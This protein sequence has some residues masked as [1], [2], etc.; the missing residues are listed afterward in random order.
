MRLA[1]ALAPLIACAPPGPTTT[2]R[3]LTLPAAFADGAPGATT[4]AVPWRTFFADDD[5]NRLIDEALANNHDLQIALARIEVARA[6]VTRTSGARLPEIGVAATASLRRFGDYTMD[7]AGNAATEIRPGERVPV[8]YPELFVGLQASWEADLWGRLGKLH[9]AARA[10]YL[11]SIE[12]THLVVANLVADLASTYYELLAID[13]MVAITAESVEQQEHALEL[14]RVEKQTGR[15]TALAV[16]QFSAQ[17]ATTRALAAE[18]AHQ[19]RALENQ[20]TTLAG[21][22]PGPL[23]RS[24]ESLARDVPRA[25]AAGVPSDLLR[26]RPDLR[27]AELAVTASRYDVGAARAAFYPR[28]R[29][30]ATLGYQAFDP[31]FLLSTPA[32]LAYGVAG[33]LVAPLVNRAAIKADLAIANATQLE[34]MVRYQQT[35]LRSFAEVSTALYRLAQ[36]GDVVDQ[37][38]Q[39]LAALTESETTADALFRAGRATYL[40]VLLAQQTTLQSRLELV[41]ALRDRQLA[42]VHLYKALGGGWQGSLAARR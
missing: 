12:G 6:Q 41:G 2:P 23:V 38:R 11:A 5:L 21:R 8:N 42:R 18:L 7:G 40:E 14:M 31:R 33:G 20:L 9:G 35:V 34:A 39:K 19:Q 15:T 3:A 37:Q 4:A 27:A 26:Q 25:L 17:L 29:I 36:L 10:R 22:L 24:G 28:L 16:Q 30:T 32:S 13:G 1:L